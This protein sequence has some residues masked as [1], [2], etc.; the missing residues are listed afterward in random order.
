MKL[1]KIMITYSFLI[2]LLCM[3]ST[4][5]TSP[6]YSRVTPATEAQTSTINKGLDERFTASNAYAIESND[7]KEIYF[8][9]CNLKAKVSRFEAYEG[10]AV[11]AFY[12]TGFTLA[13]NKIAKEFWSGRFTIGENSNVSM[14]A[15][16]ASIVEEYVSKKL[17]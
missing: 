7:F 16:G 13:V 10:V 2:F 17:F 8:L 6:D 11:W 9:A 1:K 4:C 3:L 14:A 15:E 12:S 5:S